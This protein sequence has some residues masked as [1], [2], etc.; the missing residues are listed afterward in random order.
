MGL[1]N[2]KKQET[3]SNYSP[4]DQT[5][6]EPKKAPTMEEQLARLL[7]NQM[8][9]VANQQTILDSI[10]QTQQIMLQLAN[11][12]EETERESPPEEMP[13]TVIKKKTEKK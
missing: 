7:Q 11:P 8:T 5:I 12:P 10:M 4:P 13:K 3:V 2:K 6:E 9:I 1:F